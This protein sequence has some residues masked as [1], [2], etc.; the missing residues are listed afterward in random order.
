MLINSTAC[1]V[2]QRQWCLS[3]A[4]MSSPVLLLMSAEILLQVCCNKLQSRHHSTK[5]C[6]AIHAAG[7]HT[8]FFL[9]Y[10]C[11]VQVPTFRADPL[12]PSCDGWCEFPVSDRPNAVRQFFDAAVKNTSML[13]VCNPLAVS[14]LA[15]GAQDNQPKSPNENTGLG[16]SKHY[17]LHTSST[18]A[19]CSAFACINICKQC[20]RAEHY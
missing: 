16:V 1:S 13:Q 7:L 5:L 20:L 8:T 6:M 9:T 3:M 10:Q 17:T 15:V 19:Y 11:Q 4:A 14:S 18:Y 2:A 12:T